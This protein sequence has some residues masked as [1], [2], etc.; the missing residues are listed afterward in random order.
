MKL[1]KYLLIL[2]MIFLIACQEDKID[3][4]EGKKTTQELKNKI[5][6]IDS[7]SYA[8]LEDVFSN[9]S[10]LETDNKP[11]MIIFGKNN[12]SYCEKLKKDIQIDSNLKELI[13]NNFKSYYINISYS[14]DHDI[15]FLNKV[16]DTNS[17]ATYFNVKGTPLTIWFEQNGNKILKLEGYDKK[18]FIAALNFIESNEYKKENAFEKRLQLFSKKIMNQAQ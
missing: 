12:C 15:K 10:L 9:T 16:M 7:I 13:K 4:S 11:I 2:Q 5:E 8:G 6:S 17:L 1:L 3:T 14:K 18:Y